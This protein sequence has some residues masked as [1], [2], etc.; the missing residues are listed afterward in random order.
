MK[1][2]KIG[3]VGCG[4]IGQGLAEFICKELKGSC[5]L[6]AVCDVD[7][8]KI[9]ALKQAGN[10]QPKTMA[11]EALVKKVDFVIE[12]ATGTVATQVLRLAIAYRKEV[13]ILSVGALIN[14][15]SLVEKAKRLGVVVHVPSGAICGVDGLSA[16]SLGHIKNIYLTTSKP[17][18]GFL[19]VAYLK[20]K[21][22]NLDTLKKA[23]VVFQGRVKQA[24]EHFP[25]NINVAA[26]LMLASHFK[27]VDVCIK[28]DPMLKRNTHCIEV[29]AQ[30]ARIKIEIDNV[31]AKLNPKT[32]MLTVLSSQAMLKKIFSSFKVGN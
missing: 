27:D 2:V 1:K 13:M 23:R 3:I 24:I 10:C 22:I 32:S 19:G 4:A 16:L 26:T 7:Q 30:E 12:A 9:I 25:K 31:A 18:R 17:P 28:V 20:E 8:E 6:E 15:F 29:V 21:N 5:S 11:M 14:N